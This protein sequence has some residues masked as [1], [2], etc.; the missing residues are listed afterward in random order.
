MSVSRSALIA[1]AVAVL[2]QSGC[3][4]ETTHPGATNVK[5]SLT[6]S[7][8]SGSPSLPVVVDARVDN[9]G[10]TRV[11]HCEGCGCGTGLSFTVLGPDGVAVATSDPN[12]P[13]PLCPDHTAP[14]EPGR[15]IGDRL[16]FTGTLY[17]INSLSF[18]TPTYPAPA[19]LYTVVARFWYSTGQAEPYL[20]LERT[21][22]FTWQP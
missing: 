6:A 11:W 16:L 2:L 10:I 3:A 12:G 4:S 15:D 13:W 18:P 14:L 8:G 1:T 19:G 21:T 7:P 20:R 5:L 17:V 22:T 9:L